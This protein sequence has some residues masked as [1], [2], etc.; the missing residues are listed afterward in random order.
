M[1]DEALF[2]DICYLDKRK[3][4]KKYKFL[5][6][7]ISRKVYAINDDYVIKI[8]KG[9]D[10]VYQ[11]RI[12]NHVFTKANEAQKKYLCPI[13]WF[14]PERLIMRRAIPLT[15][16]SKNQFIDLKTIRPEKEAQSDLK[17]MANTFLLY[18]EDIISISS[19]GVYKKEN[20]LIDY[21]CT[22][23]IGDFYYR[24]FYNW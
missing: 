16:N 23:S 3:I 15:S 2:K 5:G 17:K 7:G 8:A 12:E 1:D 6:E 14:H 20:V 19:W 9:Y 21:G 24:I 22:E 13:V 18:Y 11:N 10:G 4:A